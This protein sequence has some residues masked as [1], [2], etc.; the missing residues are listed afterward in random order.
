M[1]EACMLHRAQ[2]KRSRSNAWTALQPLASLL[3]SML[4]KTKGK[5][6]LYSMRV[7]ER[8]RG[9]QMERTSQRMFLAM[10]KPLKIVVPR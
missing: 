1:T 5:A 8:K 7:T 9:S 3:F 4:L 6:L 10:I 2:T